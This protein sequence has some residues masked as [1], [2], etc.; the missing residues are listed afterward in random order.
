[1]GLV[2]MKRMLLDAADGGY[3][4]GQFNLTNMEFAQSI[5]Q[6]AQEKRSPV[7]LGVSEAYVPYMGGLPCIAGMVRALIDHYGVTV[8]VALHLDHGSSFDICLRALHAGFTSVMIDASGLPLERNIELTSRVA[9]AAHALGATVE[10]EL[11]RIA[12]R[13]DEL[14]VD[15]AEVM[16]AVPDE[17]VRLARE[18]GI[19]CLAPALGSVH[20]PY[21]GQPRLGFGR[22]EDIRRL[23]GLPLA[24]HGGSGL[25]DDEIREAIVR[26][27][28]KINVNTDNQAAFTAA[29]RRYLNEHPDA[30]DPRHYLSEAAKA[31]QA[32][33]R[34]KIELF[35]CAGKAGE[36]TR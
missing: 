17:C 35:G 2:S 21:R 5:L 27:T 7:I 6:A 26:G 34:T 3:A 28:R 14:V 8:P 11:G 4:V 23:T 1:M 15:E 32:C 33:V 22:M 36:H 30:Y 10:A 25:P 29:I 13:E 16:Y 12:G 31:V 19:D 24:L 18:T 9:Q 20:G